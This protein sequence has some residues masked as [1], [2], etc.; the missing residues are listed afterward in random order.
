MNEQL[1]RDAA[2]QRRRNNRASAISTRVLEMLSH[3][4]QTQRKA[5]PKTILAQLLDVDE[6]TIRRDIKRYCALIDE[7]IPYLPI[8]LPRISMERHGGEIFVCLQTKGP[9][10]LPLDF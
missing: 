9:R 7:S 10:K 1:V 4:N 6:R 2:E 8:D 5:L 3:L